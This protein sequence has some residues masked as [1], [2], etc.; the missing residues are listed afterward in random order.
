[1]TVAVAKQLS[2]RKVI[3]IDIWDKMEIPWN[4]PENAYANAKIERGYK[5]KLSSERTTS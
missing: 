4:S 2:K 1:M 5:T 3:G